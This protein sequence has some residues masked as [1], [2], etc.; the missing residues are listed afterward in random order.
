MTG[1]KRAE[2]RLG[3]LALVV[4]LALIASAVGVGTSSS[5]A[6]SARTEGNFANFR[7]V[8][9]TVD[10]LEPAQAYTG[11]SWSVM[12]L[13]YDTLITYPHK[14][15]AHGGGRL[16]PGLAAAMPKISKDG[17]TYIFKLRPGLKYSNGKPLKAT[18][19]RFSIE[20]LYRA[21]SQ[22]VGFYTNIVGAEAYSKT[23]KGH[24]TG[25]VGN[26]AKRTVTFHLVKPRG[27]FL[28]ILA[29]L[30][31]SPV[32]AGTPDADQST[33]D[34]PGTGGYHII[35]YIPNQGFS[36]VRNKYF[37]PSKWDPKP[38]PNKITVKL[39]GDGNAAVQ[40]VINGQADADYQ[41]AIPPDRLGQISSRYKSRLKLYP[42]ANTYYFWMNTRSPVFS[43]LKARQAVNYAINRTAMIKAV[44]GGLGKSTQ[45]VLP[46]NYPQYKK[47][48]IY[49]YNLAKAR[50]LVKAAGVNGAHI[51][52]WGRAVSDSQQATTLMAD[53]LEQI[54]F[55]TTIKILPRATYYTTIGNQSTQDRDIGWARWLEDYPHPSDWFDVLLNGDRITQTNNNNYSDA[56]VGKINRMINRLNK[57]PL[58][59]AVNN[60]WAK[61]DKLVVQ[62][63]LWAPWVNR[64]FTDFLGAKFSTACYVNQPIYHFD[65]SRA[66]TK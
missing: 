66:C 4:G 30:F 24:I 3:V 44:F 22:G 47:V 39:I 17:K 5:R 42:T 15:K 27:D 61:V 53:T 1:R 25:I 21:A 58:S 55:H 56:N 31:A 28:S 7:L 34:L 40:Q 23:F 43:K 13:T 26:N 59:P 9:D 41:V 18:D 48:S 19:F 10:Y 49:K 14:D 16:V 2:R 29:L 8:L 51:T 50:S 46:P 60:Q 11:E 12:W 32:P 37:K 63:A 64:V 62:N 6:A 35:N 57:M 52:V 38:R 20:R 36:L 54:G 45:Q 65:Y 33:K